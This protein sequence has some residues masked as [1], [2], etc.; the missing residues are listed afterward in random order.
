MRKIIVPSLEDNSW[1]PPILRITKKAAVYARRSDPTAKSKDTDKSQSREMQTEELLAWAIRSSWQE[2][3]VEP[4]FADLGLSGTLRPDERPDMLRLFDDIDKGVYNHGSVICYQE[5]RLFRDETQIY[6]NQFIKKCKDHDVV[7]VVVSPYTMI[8][9]FQDDFLTEM[10][11]WKCKEAG[12]WIKR[13]VK[14]WM[15]PARIRAA[16]QGIWAGMGDISIG[17]IVD[18]DP[19]SN[20]YKRFVVYAPHAVIVQYLFKRFMELAGDFG[21]LCKE[22][23]DSPLM[24]PAYPEEITSRYITKSRF[25]KTSQGVIR[26]RSVLQSILTNRTYLGWRIVKGEVVNKKNH[27]LIVEEQLF[28]FAFTRLTGCTLDGVPLENVEEAPRRFYH[29]KTAEDFSLLK[30]RIIATEGSI[31]THVSGHYKDGE[32]GA[33]YVYHS[34]LVERQP[35]LSAKGYIQF[36][37]VTKFDSLVTARLFEHIRDISSL[38]TYDDELAEKRKEKELQLQSVIES[39]A[40]IPI[41]QANIADQIGKT[42]NENV[43]SILLAQIEALEGEHRKLL[44]LKKEMEAENAMSLRTLD[45]ELQDLELYWDEYPIQKRVALV[46]F[47]VRKVVIDMMS[48]HWLR[49]QIHWLHEEWGTEQIYYCR[50]NYGTHRWS[51]KE[52]DLMRMHYSDMPRMELMKTLNTRSWESIRHRGT[53][54][55]LKRLG[56]W[57]KL[58]NQKMTYEDIIFMEKEGLTEDMKHTN[59]MPLSQRAIR[60]AGN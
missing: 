25:M 27:E 2:R 53:Y 44:V 56:A 1:K 16:K 48:L 24:F 7:V 50:D 51:R 18:D 37:N 30:D 58:G 46:N 17:Y 36:G 43:R 45:E 14:G 6:Y 5:S 26:T 31:H 41:Q 47:L 21:K 12:E 20:Q 49:I 42:S 28:T 35:G 10:F 40:Q 15:H 9:D 13:Q 38:T 22:M 29:G 11:R 32:T 33:Y 59:W 23:V 3:D 8:Y 4:Y 60:V 52:D 57:E 55:G 54:L 34:P 19:K 39:V